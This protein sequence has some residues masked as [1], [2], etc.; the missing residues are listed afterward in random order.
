MHAFYVSDLKTD[1]DDTNAPPVATEFVGTSITTNDVDYAAVS[2]DLP[3]NPQIRYFES[4]WRGYLYCE[5]TPQ[6][7][8]TDLRIVDD[9]HNAAS[10]GR[11]LARFHVEDG[12][13][14]AQSG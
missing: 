14:G 8:R 9:A 3:H 2:A 7:W 11:T 6:S 12:R 4:R 10:L 1:F 5:I 13:P